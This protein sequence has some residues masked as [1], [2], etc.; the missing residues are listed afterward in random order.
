MEYRR[1]GRLGWG[2]S[3]V[4]YGMW[5]MGGDVS[6]WTGGDEDAYRAALSRYAR[7]GPRAMRS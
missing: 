4:G 7:S 6:G 2:V 1:F 3:A 5:G